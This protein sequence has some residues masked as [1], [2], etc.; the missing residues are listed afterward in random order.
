MDNKTENVEGNLNP[1]IKAVKP[2]G[3]APGGGG[4]KCHNW[5]TEQGCRFTRNCRFEHPQ[6]PDAASRCWLCSS[7]MHRKNDCPHRFGAQLQDGATGGSGEKG[8]EK[9]KA[10][11]K[12]GGGKGKGKNNKGGHIE[13]NK[14]G[15]GGGGTSMAKTQSTTAPVPPSEKSD[16]DSGEAPAV[17]ATSLEENG[18]NGEAADGLLTEVTS[19]L[20]SL[21]IHQPQ[22]KACNVV[23]SSGR[24]GGTMLLDGGATHC[25]RRAKSQKE[26]QA[27]VPVDVQLA[28]GSMK[29]R[30][31]PTNKTLMVEK[32]DIQ[33]IIPVNKLARLGYEVV[34]TKAGCCVRHGVKGS[35]K[36][37]MEQGCPTVEWKVGEELMEEIEKAEDSVASLRAVFLGAKT[38]QSEEEKNVLKLKK[39]FP[40]VPME[41]LERV[42]GKRQWSGHELPFNRRRRR[43]I[44]LARTVVV[45][46]FAGKADPRW[47]Q[48][49]KDGVVVICLDVLGGCDLLNNSSLAGCQ[50]M[51]ERPT[52]S[53]SLSSQESRG[54]RTTSSQRQRKRALWTGIA[55]NSSQGTS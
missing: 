54:S 37:V 14:N 12:D 5:G 24:D 18:K 23:K 29:M 13:E 11:S 28:S 36:I 22:V 44:E 45:H 38:A 34:W 16:G 42:P 20:K 26:W 46:L 3:R 7:S 53:H 27:G 21:R 33:P 52:V 47:Q 19:L 10:K 15:G 30:I 4:T 49:E 32:D 2:G 25:L 51:D 1:K 50:T 35:L 39:I 6:L 8:H 41:L 55:V 9:G 17:K 43:Q 31:N 40:E 48:Q